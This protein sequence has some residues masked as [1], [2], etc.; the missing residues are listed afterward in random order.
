MK[1]SL[2]DTFKYVPNN[3]KKQLIVILFLLLVGISFE[4]LSF[5]IFIPALELIINN[6]F[7]YIEKFNIDKIFKIEEL[8]SKILISFFLIA[9]VSIFLIKNS[10][11]LFLNWF[12]NKFFKEV[13][14]LNSIKLFDNYL[15][16]SWEE[17]LKKNSADIIRNIQNEV[18][19][20][21]ITINAFL[22]LL[23]EILVFIIILFFLILW[24]PKI[25]MFLIVLFGIICFLFLFLFKKKINH[26]AAQ[27][28]E[29]ESAFFKNIR[30][31]IGSIKEIKIL[32]KKNMFIDE[33][34]SRIKKAQESRL[35]FETIQQSPRFFLEFTSV[36]SISLLTIYFL[37][38][39]YEMN[40]VLV[41]LGLIAIALFRIM[42]STNRIV[43]NIN[44]IRFGM[45]SVRIIEKEND[46]FIKN[47]LFIKKDEN[48]KENIRFDNKIELKNI[49]FSYDES[50]KKIFNNLNIEIKKN[51][52][53][54]IVGSS[55]SGKT[56]FID[57]L[58]GLILNR[59]GSLKV[60]G[61]EIDEKN[62]KSYQKNF[63]YI[64]QNFYLFDNSVRQN[65]VINQHNSKTSNEMEDKI[66]LEILENLKLN[67]ILSEKGL[68]TQ[69]GEN[70]I[71]LSGGQRQRLGIAR[72]LFHNKEILLLDEATNALDKQTE[73]EI[74]DFIYAMRNKKTIIIST[75]NIGMLK[76]CDAIYEIK[77]HNI[78]RIK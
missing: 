8:N 53:I 50:K 29:N 73:E 74:F 28:Q 57:I 56:T 6:N 47:G 40:E 66:I 24:N 44:D 45:N 54:G 9:I 63:G 1:T 32:D 48:D 26:W 49:E 14:T 76:R 72:I 78:N 30:E 64:P 41:N 75:H 77:N 31:S 19:K 37:I 46:L 36:L 71:R 20:I 42:P 65:I 12:K 22:E 17:H 11:L 7:Y 2:I 13:Y 62:V 34:N 16:L 5:A 35:R 68:D 70:A 18:Q 23:T 3:K 58:V 59:K 43:K 25:V 61:K 52:I 67:K 38:Q 27:I 60:D 4:G 10:Y 51:T 69:V 39:D 15:E 55:G 21:T 33:L